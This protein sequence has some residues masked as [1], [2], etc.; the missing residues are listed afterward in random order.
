MF[1]QNQI[2]SLPNHLKKIKEMLADSN[3]VFLMVSYIRNSGVDIILNELKNIILNT[4]VQ[5]N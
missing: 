5:L 4:P 1:I 3:N 2:L